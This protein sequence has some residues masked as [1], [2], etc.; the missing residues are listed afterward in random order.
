L[1][2]V[3][4]NN[5]HPS[6]HLLSNIDFDRVNSV[7]S[8]IDSV[9]QKGSPLKIGFRVNVSFLNNSQPFVISGIGIKLPVSRRLYHCL[10]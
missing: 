9:Q 4:E 8:F 2:S 5:S 1:I 10:N 3:L 6:D 7:S